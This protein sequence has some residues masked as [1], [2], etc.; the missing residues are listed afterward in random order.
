M[1]HVKTLA[2]QFYGLSLV[3]CHA[4]VYEF[5]LINN[6]NNNNNNNTLFGK[7]T[8]KRQVM[9]LGNALINCLNY[10]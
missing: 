9:A 6:N 3:K 4:L 10:L 8:P 5:T 2:N 7:F 1:S